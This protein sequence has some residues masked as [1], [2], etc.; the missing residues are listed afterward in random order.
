M[1]TVYSSILSGDKESRSSKVVR[2]AGEDKAMLLI[3]IATSQSIVL[4]GDR[5]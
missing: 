2:K 3:K 4:V 5:R 1:Y